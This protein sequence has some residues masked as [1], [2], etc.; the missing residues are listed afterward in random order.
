MQLTPGTGSNIYAIK[1]EAVTGQRLW[2]RSLGQ[3]NIGANTDTLLSLDVSPDGYFL[4]L[5]FQSGWPSDPS[6]GNLRFAKLSTDQ[7]IL[8][9]VT[10]IQTK[11]ASAYAGRTITTGASTDFNF[12]RQIAASQNYLFVPHKFT[13]AYGLS[14]TYYAAGLLK[15]NTLYLEIEWYYYVLTNDA[16]N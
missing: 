4:F 8:L 1:Y 11:T 9:R 10:G 2:V 5:A 12:G 6:D 7:G 15:L 16:S 3:N 14:P 13:K